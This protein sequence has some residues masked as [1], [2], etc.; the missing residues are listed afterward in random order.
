[1]TTRFPQ[2]GA[3]ESRVAIKEH[4]WE[5]GNILRL[6]LFLGFLLLKLRLPAVWLQLRYAMARLG[7]YWKRR[8][9]TWRKHAGSSSTR[10]I[11]TPS[12][13]MPG[14]PGECWSCGKAIWGV[15]GSSSSQLCGQIQAILMPVKSGRCAKNKISDYP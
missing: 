15:P 13:P 14:R 10:W 8:T 9:E 7:Q 3:Y 5:Y 6:I 2:K 1:M 12:T 11:Q 4:A